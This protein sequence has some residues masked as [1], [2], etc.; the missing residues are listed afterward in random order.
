MADYETDAYG[1]AMQTAAA[2]R[3]R[4]FDAVDWDSVAE[5]IEGVARSERSA[6]RSNLMQILV[7]MLKFEYQPGMSGKSW[8]VSIREHRQRIQLSLSENPSL[9]PSLE[10]TLA[11]AYQLARTRASDQTGLPLSTFPKQ[12]QWALKEVV[13]RATKA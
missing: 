13:G 8:D 9:K 5:E 1:W 3:E 7:H 11:Q 2:L 4:R 6:L 10:K 12:C